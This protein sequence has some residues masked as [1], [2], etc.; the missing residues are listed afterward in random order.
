MVEQDIWSNLQYNVGFGNHFESEAEKGA[1]VKGRNNPQ[2]APMG[3][4]GEQLSGTPFTFAKH[5]NKRSWLY[6]ILPTCKHGAWKDITEDY[7]EW[8]SNFNSSTPDLVVSPSQK[9]W[10]PQDYIEGT[11]INGVRTMMGAGSPDMKD[12]LS[13]SYFSCTTSM[14][15]KKLAVYSSD[16]DFLIVP[17]VGTLRITTEFGKLTVGQKEIC[18]IPRGIKFSV[19]LEGDKARGWIAECFKGH[20]AIPDLGP[21]GSNGLANERDFETPTAAYSDD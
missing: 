10:A 18:V 17:Q 5:K 9:R 19:D 16:G 15:D 14:T 8:V 21:I 20:F 1:L 4:Y 7:S 3:L 6:R 11:F 13:I 12:G 2:K